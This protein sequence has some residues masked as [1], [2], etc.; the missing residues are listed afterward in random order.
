MGREERSAPPVVQLAVELRDPGALG[1]KCVR[2]GVL[3][4]ADE[5]HE[6]EPKES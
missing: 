2:V 5:A 1:G 4:A 6:P 3:K